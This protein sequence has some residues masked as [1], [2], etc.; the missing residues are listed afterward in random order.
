M[1]VF[2]LVLLTSTVL[3]Y[4]AS[5]KLFVWGA[6]S[7][8]IVLATLI[9]FVRRVLLFHDPFGSFRI[10]FTFLSFSLHFPS[11]S[12][13]VPFIFPSFSFHFLSFLL[14][15]HFL[16]FSFHV[17]FVFISFPFVFLSFSFDFPFLYVLS[18]FPFMFLS[19]S[20]HVSFMFLSCSFHVPFV[21]P[22]FSFHGHFVSFC[23]RFPF[24][25]CILFHVA[26]GRSP[27]ALRG[28][29]LFHQ[30][31]APPTMSGLRWFWRSPLPTLDAVNNRRGASSHFT[32]VTKGRTICGNKS[33]Y[34]W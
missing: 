15:F 23:F 7:L 13:H 2:K 6:L 31:G 12:F 34:L 16:S 27:I 22:S 17:H 9:C 28:C 1:Y 24:I 8:S 20:F 5:S 32:W 4:V 10:P 25:Y 18:F 29:T 19:C 21:F 30:K 14:S 26:K 3:Q 33:W 11:C